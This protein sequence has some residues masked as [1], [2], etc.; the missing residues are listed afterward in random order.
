VV[1]PIAGALA[2]A[3]A[4]RQALSDQHRCVILATNARDEATWSPQEGL[5][6][7]TGPAPADRGVRC[8]KAPQFLAASRDRKKPARSMA[9]LMVMTVCLLVYAALAS[10]IRQAL[11]D[12][13]TTVPNHKGQP[14]RNPTARW[15]FQSFGGIHV[16]R[17]PGQWD[18]LGVN[19][20][21]QPQ[22]LLALLGP[23]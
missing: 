7:D 9:L 15:V 23:S 11:T 17:I 12:H 6:G 3:R 21:A 13:H 16:L 5:H 19:L 10:R 4:R 22:Q 8:L 1:D 2:S 18:L 20:T 14:V